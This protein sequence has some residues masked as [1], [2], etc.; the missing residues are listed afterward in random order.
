MVGL[1]ISE[2]N[3]VVQQLLTNK[4]FRV[5][6][7]KIVVQDMGEIV[8]QAEYFRKMQKIERSRKESQAAR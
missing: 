8:K 6:E 3:V 4:L 7:N 2:G 5:I 1:P